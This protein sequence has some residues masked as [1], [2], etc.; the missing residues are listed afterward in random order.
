MS[1]ALENHFIVFSNKNQMFSEGR[2]LKIAEDYNNFFFNDLKLL[3]VFMLS[4][5]RVDKRSENAFLVNC[6]N[7]ICSKSTFR[8]G[9]TLL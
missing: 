4:F 6:L 9:P 8:L 1:K 5:Q 3:F 2:R 7:Y